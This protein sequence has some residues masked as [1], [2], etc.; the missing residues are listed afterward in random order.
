MEQKSAVTPSEQLED[1]NT[2][3]PHKKVKCQPEKIHHHLTPQAM[4]QPQQPGI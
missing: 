1:A 4:M 2:P 3:P